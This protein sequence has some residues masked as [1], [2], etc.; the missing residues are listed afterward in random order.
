M[1]DQPTRRTF[2]G[3]SLGAGLVAVAL[4]ACAQ[5]D[6]QKSETSRVFNVRDFGARGDGTGDDAPAFQRAIDAAATAGGG[7]VRFD[8]GVFL[9]RLRAAQNG[10]GAEAFTLRSSVILEGADRARSVLRLADGQHG[11]GTFARIVSSAGT[12]RNATLRNF[13]LDGNRAGQGKFRDDGN[14]GAVV[15]GWGDRC[16]NVTVERVTVRD[17]NG[18]GIMVLGA[19]GNP[20]RQ[21][22]IADCQVERCSYIGIQSSQFDGLVIERNTVL[23]CTDNGIDIYGNDDVA[24]SVV[25]TSRN[26]MIRANTVRGCSVGIFLETVADCQTVDNDITNCRTAGIRINRINGE[27]RN[28]KVTGNRI[29]GGPYGIA[30]GGD[31]GG[32]TISGNIIRGFNDGGIQFSY[33]VSHV[34]VTDNQF[35][36]AKPTVPIVVGDPVQLGRVPEE[37]LAFITIRGN[38]VP[39]GHAAT[40]M[41]VNNYRR[42][43]Q[44]DTGDF[45]ATLR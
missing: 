18:Q 19:N 44:L 8:P 43:F 12:L 6:G 28:L 39:P 4:P 23:D 26:G 42:Q 7:T 24:H 31:T 11:V 9:L 36:P 13:T 32:V 20:G 5:Q 16:E 2:I 35:V 41:F 25:A 10:H 37:Q 34:T 38:R 29:A 14:G 45:R 33:N 3:L 15:M 40:R 17:A 21:L 22:R 30:M 1:S 27:P